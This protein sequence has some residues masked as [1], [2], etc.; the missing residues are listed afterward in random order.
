MLR[1]YMFGRANTGW[2]LHD[3]DEPCWHMGLAKPAAVSKILLTLP[4][5]EWFDRRLIINSEPLFTKRMEVLTQDILGRILLPWINFDP[6]ME[7]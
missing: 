6:R 7:K 2:V 1:I 3:T 4:C 5:W